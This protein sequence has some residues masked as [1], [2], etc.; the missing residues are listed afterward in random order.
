MRLSLSIAAALSMASMR[1]CDVLLPALSADFGVPVGV[2]GWSI[3]AF[4]LAYGLLQLV[5][6]PLG[7]SFGKLRVISAALAACSVANVLAALAPTMT[8]LAIAR[9]LSGAAAAGIIPMS[10][11]RIS[12]H[13][14]GLLELSAEDGTAIVEPGIVC[15]TL[16]EAAEEH[17][18][19]F[20]LGAVAIALK[21]REYFARLRRGAC[22][23]RCD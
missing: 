20:F 6:G 12:K 17:G 13:C 11:A 5:Y 21:P 14:N 16:R 10:M 18:L 4:V 7:D 23:C 2:A 19:T 22:G 15:D 9:G 1:A 3:S 8:A